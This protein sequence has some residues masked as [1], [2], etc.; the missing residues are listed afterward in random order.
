MEIVGIHD[1]TGWD[2]VWVKVSDKKTRGRWETIKTVKAI[3]P[4]R[5]VRDLAERLLDGALTSIEGAMV[6]IGR[7]MIVVSSVMG[8]ERF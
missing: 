1:I 8:V 6:I 2:N 3:F 4:Q 7:A 5:Q